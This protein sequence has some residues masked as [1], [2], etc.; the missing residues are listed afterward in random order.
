MIGKVKTGKSFGGCVRYNL[1]RDQATILYADGIRT[2]SVPH[3]IQDFNMQRK[4]NL[5]LGQ[6][7]GHIV[8]SWSAEDKGKL[9]PGLMA[10]RAKEYL[11]KMKIANTQC[12]V[13][14]HTDRE[15][16]HIHIIYNRVDNQAKTISDQFQWKRNAEVCKQLTL[17]HSYHIAKGK[18]RV[19]RPRLTGADKIRYELYDMISKAIPQSKSWRE[20]ESALK[21]Q[22]IG[23]EYKF[24]SGS[25]EVQGV[26][27]IKGEAKFKGSAIDR[28]LSYSNLNRQLQL[29][30]LKGQQIPD[31]KRHETHISGTE[32]RAGLLSALLKPSEYEEP[33]DRHLRKRKKPE[34]DISQGRSL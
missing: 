22:D 14:Q 30:Q 25:T 6:A 24:K 3:I 27:F 26:S 28:S 10:D 2:D 17:K 20:L 7:V 15:H 21:K 18:E 32:A 11:E 5:E 1:E 23:L 33:V 13:V 8:L 29:N 16:P 12:L 34:H 31:Q 9:N 4:I 19:N